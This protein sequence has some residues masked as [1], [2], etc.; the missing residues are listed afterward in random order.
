MGIIGYF[1][2]LVLVTALAIRLDVPLPQRIVVATAPPVAF[3]FAVKLSQ[4]VFGGER[5]VFYEQLLVAQGVS[6]LALWITG[7][8]LAVGLDLVTL[9]IGA[10]LAF[11][12]LGC[13]MVGCCHGR[14]ARWGVRYSL[15]HA[16]AGFTRRW[17]SRP[18]FPI[19]LVDSALSAALVTAGTLLVLGPHRPG[20]AT[21]LYLCGY[22][23]GRFVLELFRGDA[24]R[25]YWL[26]V[27]EAQWTAAIT[28]WGVVFVFGGGGA[29]LL[30]A[31]A[32]T[33]GSIALIVARRMLLVSRYWLTCPDHVEELHHL[34]LHAAPGAAARVTTL[35]L[36]LSLRLLPGGEVRDYI[37]SHASRQ[38]TPTTARA[39][40]RQL[41]WEAQVQVGATAGL[42]HL[43][44]QAPASG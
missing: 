30:V 14:P 34:A 6:A 40:A 5:I 15:E 20:A 9:G 2:A 16:D 41:G 31:G 12:R 39:V 35:G 7:G 11:G 24:A 28:T 26:G 13:F 3:L 10:F 36:R 8:Q 23:V 17:V 32:L 21:A 38:L 44:V 42:V 33:A 27:S 37:L 4:I 25:P 43:L 22:G 1:V 18:L 29:P 19:Q